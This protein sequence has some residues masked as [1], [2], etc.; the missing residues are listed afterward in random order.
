VALVLVSAGFTCNTCWM[1]RRERRAAERMGA[2][3]RVGG[4]LLP[5]DFILPRGPEAPRKLSQLPPSPGDGEWS[6]SAE[7][8]GAQAPQGPQPEDPPGRRSPD[9][10]RVALSHLR[11]AR[12]RRAEVERSIE[13][14]VATARR[15]GVRWADIGAALGVTGEGARVRYQVRK[16]PPA[17]L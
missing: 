5:S 7:G 4:G 1:G 10:G 12:A 6:P 11:Q 17:A 13:R 9:P 2:G 3:K 16:P 15:H 14:Q 8:S